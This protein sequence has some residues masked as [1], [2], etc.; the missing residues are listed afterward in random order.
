MWSV[1][2]SEK[3]RT[4]IKK[5][6]PTI[7]LDYVPGGCTSVQQPCDV[8]IQRPLKLSIRQ[9]YHEDIVKEMR[10]KLDK[11]GGIKWVDD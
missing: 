9:S 10:E 8:G 6:H 1:H 3:F 7:L 2:Q 5:E 11:T 4:W